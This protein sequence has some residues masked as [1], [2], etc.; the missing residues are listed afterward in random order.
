MLHV[1][2]TGQMLLKSV[3]WVVYF[4]MPHQEAQAYCRTS[5]N[6]EYDP[7]LIENIDYSQNRYLIDKAYEIEAFTGG[8]R[9][10]FIGLTD[11]VEEGKWIW[12]HSLKEADDFFWANDQPN[13]G[14]KENI[15]VMQHAYE[16]N[17]GDQ[18]GNAQGYPI[19]QIF[20]Y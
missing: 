17:W 14:T 19:C 18:P 12:S 10:W 16:Y 1:Q 13:G 9:D 5:T 2:D 11:G 20:N 4:S 8:P 7:H 6:P 15:V 3:V